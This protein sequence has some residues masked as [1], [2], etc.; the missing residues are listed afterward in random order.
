MTPT[1]VLAADGQVYAS[2]ALGRKEFEPPRKHKPPRIKLLA[3]L[4]LTI[5]YGK[6]WS[7]LMLD[8]IPLVAYR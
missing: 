5:Q 2:A 8:G 6:A 4:V 7:Q 3:D 1:H